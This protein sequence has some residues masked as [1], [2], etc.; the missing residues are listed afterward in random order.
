[1][2]ALTGA[3]LKALIDSIAAQKELLDT[4]VGDTTTASTILYGMQQ[5]VDRIKAYTDEDP[6]V[7]LEKKFAGEKNLMASFALKINQFAFKKLD[8]HIR[9]TEDM[10]FS[11]YWEQE[12]SDRVPYSAALLG[13]AAGVYIKASLVYPP[14]T[15]MGTF[16][17]TGAGTGTFT[18]GNLID[19]DLYG[20]ADLELEVTAKGGASVSLVAT[21]TGTDENGAVVTG[22]GEFVAADVGD[23]VNVT[24]DQTGKQFQDVTNITITGGATDDAFKCQSKVDRTPSL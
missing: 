10:S 22:S 7:D 14:V 19:G 20:P 1:M 15:V 12:N 11:D 5:N 13:R 2:S 16:V 8:Y 17:A 21:V 6:R 9:R 23:K 3:E 18:D 4:T 24:P